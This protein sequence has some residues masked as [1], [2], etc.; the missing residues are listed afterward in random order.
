MASKEKKEPII[1]V[2]DFETTV[3]SQDDLKELGMEEQTETEV[4]SAAIMKSVGP[5]EIENEPVYVYNNIFE[6]MSHLERL[7]DGSIVYFHNLRFDGSY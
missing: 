6:F 2:A 3:L 1:Y 4:W 5:D 7:E